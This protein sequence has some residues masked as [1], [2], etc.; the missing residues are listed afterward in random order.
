MREAHRMMRCKLCA[1]GLALS[2]MSAE[3]NEWC[4]C[5]RTRWLKRRGTTLRSSRSVLCVKGALFGIH[6]CCIHY[7]PSIW[8]IQSIKSGTTLRSSRSVLIRVRPA[9]SG[10]HLESLAL[11]STMSWHHSRKHQYI[12]CTSP[13]RWRGAV[14]HTH[15][16]A[17][18]LIHYKHGIHCIRYI[19]Y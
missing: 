7:R 13:R 19:D 4:G 6:T 15:T 5:R 11:W 17:L 10:M 18:E 9:D 2:S 16:N 12:S 14:K 3:L 8:R 1:L